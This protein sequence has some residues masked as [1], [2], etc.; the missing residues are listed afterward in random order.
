MLASSEAGSPRKRPKRATASPSNF[1]S[2]PVSCPN[3]D[4]STSTERLASV[5][6]QLPNVRPSI[7]IALRLHGPEPAHRLPDVFEGL[8]REALLDEPPAHRAERIHQAARL[9]SRGNI[10]SPWRLVLSRRRRRRRVPP[11]SP[12]RACR[13]RSRSTDRTARRLRPG[14]Y[15]T[16]GPLAR[17]IDRDWIVVDAKVGANE[18]TPAPGLPPWS[19]AA[20][21]SATA[22]LAA[23]GPAVDPL[24][25]AGTLVPARVAAGPGRPGA[26]SR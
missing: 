24:G 20:S 5:R 14:G 15:W 23:A 10:P 3:N 13:A 25:A 17:R 26:L 16:A 9:E 18:A 7:T 4:A 11:R 21:A 12:S 22:A 8:P 6:F 19:G 1:A 2:A